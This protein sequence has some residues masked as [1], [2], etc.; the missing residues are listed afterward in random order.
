MSWR[1]Q[2]FKEKLDQQHTF[3]GSY[4]FKFIVPVDKEAEVKAL[5]DAKDIAVKHSKNNNYSS[6]TVQMHMASSD[7]VISVYEE[8]YKIEGII[9]L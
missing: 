3:P 4:K 9:S 6:I 5:F 1:K 8:A 7:H 2:E